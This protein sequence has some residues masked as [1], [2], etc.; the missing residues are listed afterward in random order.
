MLK[1]FGAGIA[2]G[3]ALAYFFDPEQGRRRRNVARD[4]A[5]AMF[6]RA[7]SEAERRGRYYAG[8]AEGL[9]HKASSMRAHD[10]SVLDDLT[11]KHKIE[12][13]VLRDLDR[14]HVNV[15]VDEGVAELRGA[16]ERPDQISAIIEGVRRVPGIVEVRSF[17]HLRGALS[18]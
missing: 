1:R 7:E 13:E 3:A 12:S 15:N 14:S 10:E 4:R 8:K 9:K 16:L 11:L 6:R 17:L 18:G 5:A 2:A